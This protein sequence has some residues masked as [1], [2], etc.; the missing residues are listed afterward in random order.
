MKPQLPPGMARFRLARIIYGVCGNGK[1]HA[2]RAL[3]VMRHFPQHRFLVLSQGPSLP[4][5]AREHEVVEVPNPA[6]VIEGHGLA[7]LPTLGRSLAVLVRSPR[8]LAAVASVI[9]DFA[10]DRAI[11]DWEVF[12][13]LACRRSGL[14]CLSLDHQ[15]AALA[16]G[17]E[18]PP[19][20][21]RSAFMTRLSARVLYSRASEY[22]AVSFFRPRSPARGRVRVRPPLLRPEVLR[23]EPVS[24]DHVLVYQGF[25]TFPGFSDLLRGAG[26]PVRAYGLGRGG[27]RGNVE[28][29][30]FSEQGFLADLAACSYVICGGGHSLISEALFLGKPVLSFPQKDMYEQQVNAHQLR[31][32]GWG[33]SHAGLR[34]ASDLLERFEAGLDGYRANIARGDFCGNDLVLREVGHFIAHG[35][36]PITE[37]NP[38]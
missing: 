2:M 9:R 27:R 32:N 25:P 26:R 4:L 7:L 8:H 24:G 3:A 36:L 30:E 6:T 23:R 37:G 34:P 28:Y 22:L 38:A 16:A 33:M 5:L 20:T 19:G 14:P 1:G 13:P 21:A 31:I 12:L 17:S 10:P 29:K 18:P 15:H 11:A 35:A